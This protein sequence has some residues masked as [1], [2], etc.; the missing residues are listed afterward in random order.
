MSATV[1]WVRD[2]V[3][4]SGVNCQIEL[5]GGTRYQFGDTPDVRIKFHDNRILSRT[6]DEMS[7]AE[8][9][10]N[11]VIDIDG[12][13]RAVLKLRRHIRGRLPFR[14]WLKFLFDL[15]RPETVVNRTAVRDHYQHDDDFYLSFLDR[16]YRCYSHGIYQHAH[17]SLE[18]GTEHK[19][20]NMF[21]NL[22][23][24]QH[25]PHRSQP[26]TVEISLP[27]AIPAAHSSLSNN[28]PH[29]A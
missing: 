2:I 20:E 18:E 17:E 16:K 22:R 23:R 5:P 9:Y 21:R 14:V 4:G 13:I 25:A 28:S 10:I 29:A 11:G 6:L 27:W 19:V 1:E 12:D 15:L 8:A 3:A 7:F 24:N 26:I